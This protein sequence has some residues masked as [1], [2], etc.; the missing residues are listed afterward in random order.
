MPK[1]RLFN[2]VIKFQST[3][4]IQSYV[5]NMWAYPWNWSSEL[6]LFWKST[7]KIATVPA[8]SEIKEKKKFVSWELIYQIIGII[9]VFSHII[10]DIFWYIYYY[11]K[12]FF[13]V[14]EIVFYFCHSKGFSLT[15]KNQN[16]KR[17]GKKKN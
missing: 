6:A 8:G 13:S 4:E 9:A 12:I 2:F 11:E 17:Y 14:C 7:V 15:A 3:T 5:Q 10:D 1:N 16:L